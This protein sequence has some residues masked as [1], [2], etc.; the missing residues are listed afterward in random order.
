V[1]SSLFLV[2]SVSGRLT[3]IFCSWFNAVRPVEPQMLSVE[4]RPKNNNVIMWS[5]L[6]LG[7][8]LWL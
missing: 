3:V 8:M 5:I 4:T 2:G 6:R 7:L 1:I